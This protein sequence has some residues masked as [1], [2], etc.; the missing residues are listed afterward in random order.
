MEKHERDKC[1]RLCT[2]GANGS[3]NSD[4][5]QSDGLVDGA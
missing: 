3:F 1:L 4:S 5:P 2:K